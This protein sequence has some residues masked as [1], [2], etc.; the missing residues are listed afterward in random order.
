[1]DDKPIDKE[2]L[3][4]VITKLANS[5]DDELFSLK[6]EEL[7][8]KWYWNWNDEYSIRYNTYNFY[9]LLNLYEYSCRKWEEKHNGIVCV[10]ERVR[11]KYLMPKIEIFLEILEKKLTLVKNQ[12]DTTN[13]VK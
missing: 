7:E 3:S 11:D 1:M 5:F 12:E 8:S 13:P 6:E 9:D 4:Q 2:L 10:V